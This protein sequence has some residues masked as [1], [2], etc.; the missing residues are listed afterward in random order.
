MAEA[1]DPTIARIRAHL[2]HERRIDLP[3]HALA[4][5]FDHDDLVIEGEVGTVAAKKLALELAAATPGVNGI[6]DRLHVAPSE[7]MADEEIL[8]HLANSL[9]AESGL[10]T[11]AIQ[12]R[13]GD[14]VEPRRVPADAR[15]TIE[16]RIENGVV[17]LDGDVPGLNHKRLAESLAWWV[18]GTRDVVNGLGVTPPE[19]DSDAEI[20]DALQIV[21]A[22]DPLL[23]GS[24]LLAFTSNR[25]VALEGVVQTDQQ[26]AAAENDAWCLFGVDRV[27]NHIQ[28]MPAG[29]ADPAPTPMGP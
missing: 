24:R 6:V 1:E 5:F 9:L 26:R 15:G 16:L 12:L 29:E 3:H 28:V 22:K 19:E 20:S 7:P 10:R 17:T 27:V 8:A 14:R 13:R 21:F 11:C 2:A 4:L 25:V 18:P 23:K